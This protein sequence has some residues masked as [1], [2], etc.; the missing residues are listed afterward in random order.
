VPWPFGSTAALLATRFRASRERGAPK[1]YLAGVITNTPSNLIRWIQ[2]PQQID[3]LTVMPD[4]D[5]T[6]SNARNIASYLY[7]LR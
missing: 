4:M 6:E 2:H 7:T 3:P 5:V 1:L